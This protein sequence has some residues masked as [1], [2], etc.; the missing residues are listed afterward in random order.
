MVNFKAVLAES[1]LVAPREGQS[2]P[3]SAEDLGVFGS[4][5]LSAAL[6]AGA[7]PGFRYL[8]AATAYGQRLAPHEAL[9]HRILAS[10][11]EASVLVPV[12][13]KRRLDDTARE[14]IWSDSRLEDEDWEI[15]WHDTTRTHLPRCLTNFL[16]AFD[17]T[18]RTQEIL[19]ETWQLL[20]TAEC[21]AFGEYALATHNLNPAIARSAAP[22][23]QPFLAQ[24]SIGH[25]CA[26][27][28]YA[29]KHLAAWFLRQGGSGPNSAEREVTRSI[30]YSFNRSLLGVNPLKPFNRHNA[31][32]LSTFANVFI[33]TSGLGDEYWSEPISEAALDRARP[34][35]SP[36]PY[37]I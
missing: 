4:M 6:Q 34:I 16:D 2:S 28:W 1:V 3:A 24:L 7:E 12:P 30:A 5:A 17:S 21:L 9:R 35:G 20:G 11:I 31:V 27:M 29:V 37:A 33:R 13:S 23:L 8:R 26:A 15:R 19:L 32:P 18:A 36:G 25:G 22:S 14:T 10:L